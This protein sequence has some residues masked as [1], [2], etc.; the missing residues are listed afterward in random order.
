MLAR[1]QAGDAIL[2]NRAG[3]REDGDGINPVVIQQIFQ[4]RIRDSIMA[5]GKGRGLR[6]RAT[7]YTDKFGIREMPMNA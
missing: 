3:I 5:S 7:P 2:R 1:L 4:P 6:V